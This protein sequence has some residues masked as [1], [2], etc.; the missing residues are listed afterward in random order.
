MRKNEK[1]LILVLVLITVVAIIIWFNVRNKRKDTQPVATG[2]AQNQQEQEDPNVEKYITELADGT[3][4]NTSEEFNNSKTYKNLTIS[5][6]QYTYRNGE[7]LLLADVTNNGTE[8]CEMEIVKLRILDEKGQEI[9]TMKP[10]LPALAPGETDQLNAAASA[11]LA[12]ARDFEI[13]ENN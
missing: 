9:I 5:N 3:K 7:T 12:N 6:I 1:R 4:L 11:D 13:L 8:P 2:N 10:L